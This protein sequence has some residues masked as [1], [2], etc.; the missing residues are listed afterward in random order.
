MRSIV[1]FLLGPSLL[2]MVTSAFFSLQTA[3]TLAKAAIITL[4]SNLARRLRT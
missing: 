1:P 3:R 4:I 2:R